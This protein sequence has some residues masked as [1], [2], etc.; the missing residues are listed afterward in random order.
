MLYN[1]VRD[2]PTVTL[3]SQ[4][5]KNTLFRGASGNYVLTGEKCYRT[6][7]HSVTTVGFPCDMVCLHN[8]YY[9]T[10]QNFGGENFGG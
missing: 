3:I 8:F 7:H 4:L 1:T 9:H 10:A 5:A 2:I 6:N